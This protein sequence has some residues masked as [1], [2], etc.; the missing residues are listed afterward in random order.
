MF[1]PA[2]YIVVLVINVDKKDG[3]NIL[4]QLTLFAVLYYLLPHM[5]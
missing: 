5:Q 1:T 4:L 3:L 2:L